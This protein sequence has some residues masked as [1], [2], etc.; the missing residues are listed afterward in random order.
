MKHLYYL[1]MAVF[2]F[3]LHS[4]A[5]EKLIYST[6]FQNWDA[7]TS[8]ASETVVDKTTDFSKETLSFKLFDIE[9]NPAGEN[10]SKFTYPPATIGWAMAAKTATAQIELS[11]LKSITR[12]SFVVG[13]T[14]SNRGYK[15]WKKNATDLDWV[16]IFSDVANSSKGMEVN[17]TLNDE[18]V[19]IKFTNLAPTQ[20]AYLF[21][22]QIYGNVVATGTQYALHTSVSNEA[23]GTI[24]RTPNS[25]LYDKDVAVSLMA[26]PNFGFKFV[27]WVDGADADVST[28]NPLAVTMD[29]EK[30]LKAVFEAVTTYSLNLTI[31]GSTWGKV[32]LNPAPT[33]GKYEMGTDVTM[34]VVPN[35]VT[36]FSFWN[37]NSTETQKVVTM[38]ADKSITATFDE[39][40]FI[41]GWDF[42]AQEPRASR[43]GDF[44]S[45]TTN[46][47]LISAYEPDGT[48]VNWL[49]NLGSFSPSYACAR[50][51]TTETDFLTK[52]RYY[53][54]Q[55]STLGHTNIRI[56]SKVGGNYQVYAVQ[57]LQISLDGTNFTELGRADITTAYNASW[58]DLDATLPTEAEN[59]EKV[60]LRWIGDATSAVLGTGNDGAALTHVYVYADKT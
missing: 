45:E 8:A 10:I 49:A 2:F 33:D 20:N 27:K 1:F 46:T 31:A 23:A 43:A 41:A 58:V 38:D 11:P 16:L 22:L 4:Q 15:V 57:I 50:L 48:P 24:V 56:K 60:Y 39:I 54:A 7:V 40:P 3:A 21:N 25:D 28:E 34:T 19:A 47:G 53:Q 51:W 59:Q 6:D 13:A 42:K 37:D 5:Q 52:R 9:L 26:K 44:F 14:G 36:N 30:N 17:L 32:T 29:A 55:F 12:I 35:A 18:N